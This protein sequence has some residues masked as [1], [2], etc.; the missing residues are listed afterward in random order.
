MFG[1]LSTKPISK[2]KSNIEER[3]KTPNIDHDA[4]DKAFNSDVVQHASNSFSGINMT[5]NAA[6]GVVVGLAAISVIGGL[7]PH[8]FPAV[9]IVAILCQTVAENVR[10]RSKLIT[11][12]NEAKDIVTRLIILFASASAAGIKTNDKGLLDD[13]QDRIRLLFVYLLS[14]SSNDDL[15]KSKKAICAAFGIQI[16]SKGNITRDNN[17]IKFIGEIKPTHDSTEIIN[18]MIKAIEDEQS[19]R[20]NWGSYIQSITIGKNVKERA[21]GMK[22]FNNTEFRLQ[23]VSLLTVIGNYLALYVAEITV[24]LIDESKESRQTF[25]NSFGKYSNQLTTP[26]QPD[27]IITYVNNPMLEEHVDTKVGGKYT[28]HRRRK[29]ARHTR[30]RG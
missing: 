14:L 23:I 18:L 10:R 4:L 2:E 9:V 5:A 8:V 28:K 17:N 12:I 13:L 27:E 6:S 30:R 25:L 19:I 11:L 7:S 22:L 3:Q 16:D 20:A 21:F 15:S 26:I 1:F 29:R 24:I